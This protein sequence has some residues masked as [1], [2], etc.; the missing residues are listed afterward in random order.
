MIGYRKMA[1][2]ALVVIV[3]SGLLLAGVLPAETYTGVVKATVFAIC[4]AN[5]AEHIGISVQHML[6]KKKPGGQG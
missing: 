6:S 3:T 5:A 1:F 4:G 2:A